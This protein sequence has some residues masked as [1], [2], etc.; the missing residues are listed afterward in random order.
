MMNVLLIGG[1][2]VIGNSLTERLVGKNINVYVTTRNRSLQSFDNVTFLHGDSLN[3]NFIKEVTSALSFDVIIDFMVYRTQLFKSLIDIYLGSCKHY[4]FLS[5]YRVYSDSHGEKLTEKS[6]RILDD[7]RVGNRYRMSEEYA[8]KKA[9]QE[10]ILFAHAKNNWT[11]LRPSIIFG[12]NR[13]QLFCFEANLFMPRIERN[14]PVVIPENIRSIKT[15]HTFSDVAAEYIELLLCKSAAFGEV[16]NL[17]GDRYMVWGD[18]LDFYRENFNARFNEIDYQTFKTLYVNE[19]QVRYD[20]MVNRELSNMKLKSLI[21]YQVLESNFSDLLMTSIKRSKNYVFE[22][23]R[24]NG[25]MDKILSLSMAS[26]SG[27]IIADLKYFMGYN[28]FLNSIYGI[29]NKDSYL[30]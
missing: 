22:G 21:G 11:V 2:G 26:G 19:Y 23:G 27:K 5:S 18:I 1:T 4:I 12:I 7:N 9:K 16:F 29:I 3:T 10:D 6:L 17:C 24:I 8:I 28:T 13:F 30:K 20:R 25:R 15:T 14:K